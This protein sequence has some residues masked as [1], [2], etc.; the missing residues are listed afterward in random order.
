MINF[1]NKHLKNYNFFK[2]KLPNYTD[3]LSDH[4]LD[5]VGDVMVKEN[6]MLLNQVAI[7]C[8]FLSVFV[9]LNFHFV[10]DEFCVEI[11]INNE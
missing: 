10:N 3:Y 1:I 9:V 8:Y 11:K 6:V 2:C 5:P 7:Q 4:I